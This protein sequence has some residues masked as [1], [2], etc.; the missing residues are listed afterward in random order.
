MLSFSESNLPE[1]DID[2]NDGSELHRDTLM[3]EWDPLI[4]ALFGR[5]GVL[6]ME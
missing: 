5:M 1:I 2:A 4:V 3:G 6:P